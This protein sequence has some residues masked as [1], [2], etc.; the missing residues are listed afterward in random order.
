MSND[1]AVP[2]AAV[3]RPNARRAL[4]RTSMAPRGLDQDGEPIN[5][6]GALQSLGAK[7]RGLLD[8][9][10]WIGRKE[11][12]GLALRLVT[13]RKSPEATDAAR[14]HA[15]ARHTEVAI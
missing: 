10:V 11:G 12:A 5:I 1:D 7:Q 4:I 6:V 9:P 2:S 14:V 13:Q 8:L 3:A 15:D